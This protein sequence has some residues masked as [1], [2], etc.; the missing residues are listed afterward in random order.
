[1]RFG[2]IEALVLLFIVLLLFGATKLPGLAKS[3]GESVKI[4][5]KSASDDDAS[6]EASNEEKAT[7]NA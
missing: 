2:G 5:K 3:A 7:Q 6:G 1:M 4:F